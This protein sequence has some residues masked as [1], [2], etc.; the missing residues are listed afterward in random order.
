MV[1][2][3]V[4]GVFAVCEVPDVP[5]QVTEV[6]VE[7]AEDVVLSF[8]LAGSDEFVHQYTELFS[9]HEGLS[10][11]KVG[12]GHTDSV[13]LV[14]AG[15]HARPPVLAQLAH[16]LVFPD[17]SDDPVH[18]S[19]AEAQA[20]SR[21]LLQTQGVEAGGAVALSQYLHCTGFYP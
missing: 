5:Q 3:H 15:R 7:L 9:L 21:P 18:A 16:C 8:T 10:V 14:L 2:H 12:A 20:Q 11:G 1:T 13:H 19:Q 17:S 4:L 6:G